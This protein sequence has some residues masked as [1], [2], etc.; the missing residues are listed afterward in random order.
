MEKELEKVR[1]FFATEISIMEIGSKTLCPTMM[2]FMYSKMV[3]SIEDP[4]RIIK[5]F[6]RKNMDT[7]REMEGLMYLKKVLLPENSKMTVR[8]EWVDLKI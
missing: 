7:L 1:W 3:M 2:V 5:I 6:N 4:S 8:T